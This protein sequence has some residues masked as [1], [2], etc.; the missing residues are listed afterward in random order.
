L[1]KTTGLTQLA[2]QRVTLLPARGSAQQQLMVLSG[3]SSLQHLELSELQDQQSLQY[4]SLPSSVLQRLVQLTHLHLEGGLSDAP[5][6]HLSCTTSLQQ[7]RLQRLGA[8]TT[9]AALEAVSVLQQLTCLLIEGAHF[10]LGD[11]STPSLTALT[12][13]RSIQL[14]SCNALEPAVL[15]RLTAVQELQLRLT[16]LE[17]GEEGTVTFLTLL[18]KLHQLTALQLTAALTHAAPAAAAYSALTANSQLQDLWLSHATLG[19][20]S[21]AEAWS[22]LFPLLGQQLTQLTALHL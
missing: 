15:S 13:L 19:T 8:D 3:L 16:P 9:P 22:H 1:Q 2:L 11:V 6:Q 18:P 7:L 10:T 17:G 4:A 14:H 20:A 21:A 5:L 12:G